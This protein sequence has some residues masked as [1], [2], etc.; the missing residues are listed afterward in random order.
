MTGEPER[1]AS[2]CRKWSPQARHH[3]PAG[4][5]MTRQRRP[6]F[7]R[8]WPSSPK[9]AHH[10]PATQDLA[11][12]GCCIEEHRRWRGSGTHQE[13]PEGGAG[14]HRP[15]VGHEPGCEWQPRDCAHRAPRCMEFL[16]REAGRPRPRSV[17]RRERRQPSHRQ[18]IYK[19][20]APSRSGQTGAPADQ[21]RGP[22]PQ[23]KQQRQ[24][25]R[26]EAPVGQSLEHWTARRQ[27]RRR[28]P[29]R[30]QD[31]PR[32]VH[33]RRHNRTWSKGAA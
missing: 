25:G 27:P 14:R 16:R 28:T 32:S 5:P 10:R 15:P 19:G 8:S 6:A 17:P 4:S 31:R 26:C 2:V 18:P 7:S 24:P 33:Y 30:R 9:T 1:L 21:P 22:G 3:K 11:S 29:E 12:R 13:N 20:P 23:Q